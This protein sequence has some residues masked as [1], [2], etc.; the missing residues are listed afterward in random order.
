MRNPALAR[1]PTA[2][3]EDDVVEHGRFGIGVVRTRSWKK[4][5]LRIVFAG[6]DLV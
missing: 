2:L 4:K 3:E 6:G 5:A 1:D